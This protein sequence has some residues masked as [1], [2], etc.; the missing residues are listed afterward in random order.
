[1]VSPRDVVG[2]EQGVVDALGLR[3]HVGDEGIVPG[4][5]RVARGSVPLG[6]GA[7]PVSTPRGNKCGVVAVIL[8][9]GHRVVAVPGVEDGLLGVAWNGSGLVERGWAVVGFPGGML[10]E[11]LEIDGPPE[12][13]VLLGA[14][15]HTVAPSDGCAQGDL[16]QHA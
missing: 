3:R 12:R 10:V 7:V 13:P 5:V 16:L 11:W 15:D 4:G 14:Y 6:G 1:M 8:V 2:P 9:E